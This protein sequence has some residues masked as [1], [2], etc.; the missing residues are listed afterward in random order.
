MGETLG[1]TG[2]VVCSAFQYGDGFTNLITPALGATAGS[3]ALAGVPIGKWIKWAIP[4]VLVM[5]AY[6]WVVLYFLANAGWMGF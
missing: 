2:N 5:S 1:M 4:V 6:C 3:L